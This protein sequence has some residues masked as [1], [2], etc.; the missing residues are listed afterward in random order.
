MIAPDQQT[1]VPFIVWLSENYQKSYA[2]NKSCVS[3]KTS[4]PISHDNLFSSM[5]GLLDIET[6]VH[7]SALD[8]FASCKTISSD[9]ALSSLKK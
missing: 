7:N 4:N 8:I 5:I 3:N 2:I 1:K 6:S 9:M